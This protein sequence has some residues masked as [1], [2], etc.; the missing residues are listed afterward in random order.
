MKKGVDYVREVIAEME[1]QV[2]SKAKRKR[3]ALFFANAPVSNLTEEAK[4]EY[5]RYA[6]S[7]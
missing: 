6:E 1:A 5:R 2:K 4:E 7:R 3:Q